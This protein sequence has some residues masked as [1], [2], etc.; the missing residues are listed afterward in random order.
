MAKVILWYRATHLSACQEAFARATHLSACQEAFDGLGELG[1]F[2]GE[3]PAQ[4]QPTDFVQGMPLCSIQAESGAYMLRHFSPSDPCAVCT[5]PE[6]RRWQPIEPVGASLAP[7][8]DQTLEARVMQLLHEQHVQLQLKLAAAVAGQ[9]GSSVAVHAQPRTSSSSVSR[10]PDPSGSLEISSDAVADLAAR[11][12][13]EKRGY[14][15]AYR[16]QQKGKVA[17]MQEQ[18]NCAREALHSL[19]EMHA[20]LQAEHTALTSSQTSPIPS[21]VPE[22]ESTVEHLAAAAQ[23]QKDRAAARESMVRNLLLV[24]L[25]VFGMPEAVQTESIEEA[26]AAVLGNPYRYSS[27]HRI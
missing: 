18:L 1:R 23:S 27:P 5:V 25:P 4:P 15:K 12:I 3:L 2:F 7:V 10:S 19:A 21:S 9:A 11:R 6:A 8:R 13:Q 17:E 20:Q 26:V 16:L 22:L 24:A 14:S